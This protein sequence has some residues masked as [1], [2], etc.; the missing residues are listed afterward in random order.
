M[1]ECKTITFRPTPEAERQL[2][3]LQKLWGCKRTAA[4]IKAIGIASEPDFDIPRYGREALKE[5]SARLQAVLPSG[6]VD[7]EKIAA[8]QRRA[9]MT[10]FDKRRGK[11]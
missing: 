9:G 6:R 2:E 8:F 3:E 1:A 11:R 10:V 5:D 4:I 7:P